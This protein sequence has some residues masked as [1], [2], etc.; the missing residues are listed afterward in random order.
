MKWQ[1]CDYAQK[2]SRTYFDVSFMMTSFIVIFPNLTKFADLK[3]AKIKQ[4]KFAYIVRLSVT[5][6][7]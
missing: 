2:Y 7:L 1:N 6:I 3:H 4:N 5:T